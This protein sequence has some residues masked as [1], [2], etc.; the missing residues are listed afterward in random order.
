MLPKPRDE[1][2]TRYLEAQRRDEEGLSI[3]QPERVAQ[4][5]EL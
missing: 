3:G 5:Q 4:I 1:L 2:L